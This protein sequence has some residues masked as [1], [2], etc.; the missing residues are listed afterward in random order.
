MWGI[1]NGDGC[2]QPQQS[3]FRIQRCRIFLFLAGAFV[4]SFH[5]IQYISTTIDH[6]SLTQQQRTAEEE[7][8]LLFPPPNRAIIAKEV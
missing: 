3:V 8:Q 6:H 1:N 2:L 5:G 7:P 4:Y